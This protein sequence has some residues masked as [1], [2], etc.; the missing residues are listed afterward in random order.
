MSGRHEP[1]HA[2]SFAACLAPHLGG[3]PDPEM[4]VGDHFGAV[5]L[6]DGARLSLSRPFYNKPFT[7]KARL[8]LT[9][10]EDLRL[11]GE[12]VPEFPSAMFDGRRD[13]AQLAREI[14]RRAI[15]PGRP[16]MERARALLQ[17]VEDERRE[18]TRQLAKLKR[19]AGNLDFRC[20]PQ[21]MATD[22]PFYIYGD[23]WTIYGRLNRGTVH[24]DRVCGLNVSATAHLI[25]FLR[26]QG[27]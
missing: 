24:L 26:F 12:Y 10:A 16:V 13:P 4:I 1:I 17:T 11:R 25:S 18:F 9:R 20:D 6:P 22:A 5:L 2:A 19:A 14:K 3:A 23:G 7:I 8:S 21:P 27:A 15:V